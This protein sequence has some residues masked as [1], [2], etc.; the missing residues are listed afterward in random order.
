MPPPKKVDQLPPEIR[1]WLQ[2]TLRDRGFGD[3]VA[4]TDELNDKLAE[5]GKVVNFHH[6]TVHRFGQEYRKFVETQEKASA[7]AAGWMQ[8]QG[9]EEEAKR[10]NILFQ[11]ITTLAFKIMEAQ[12][13]REGGDLDPKD[14]HFLGRMLKDVMASSGIRETMARDMR[15]AQAA[16]LEA[17]VTSGDIDAE[18]AEKARRI[19]GFA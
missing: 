17:A 8:D 1:D 6:A 18:A 13:L 2:Q 9:I 5:A 4:I 11:M 10:H 16:K 12:M 15:K 14:L 3:Y 19:L 7:W